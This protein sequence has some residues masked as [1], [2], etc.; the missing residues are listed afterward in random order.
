MK[1]IEKVDGD[2]RLTIKFQEKHNGNYYN[3]QSEFRLASDPLNA[4]LRY[5]DKEA[6]IHFDPAEKKPWTLVTISEKSLKEFATLAEL[7]Y[8]VMDKVK[9]WV[10]N[11]D[12]EKAKSNS[13]ETLKITRQPA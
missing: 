10:G 2:S 6:I 11:D 1:P 12:F 7:R 9:E 4:R 5:I 13:P 3:A 8:A